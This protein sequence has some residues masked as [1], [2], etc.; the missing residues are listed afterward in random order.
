M[1]VKDRTVSATKT[2]PNRMKR[3]ERIS[4]GVETMIELQAAQ[5][6]GWIYAPKKP[7]SSN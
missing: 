1:T 2:D 5:L 6:E 4:P 7:E 3:M